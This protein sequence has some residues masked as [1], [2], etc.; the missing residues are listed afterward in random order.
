[1]ATGVSPA[2]SQ[3]TAPTRSVPRYRLTVPLSLTVLRS[4]IPNHIPGRALEI[5]EGGMGVVPASQ[6]LVG[7]T[8]RVEFL[9]PHLNSPVRA[10]A[11][12]RYQSERCFGVQFVRLPV[13]QQS[14]VRFWT[15]RQGELLLAAPADDAL[16]AAEE[17]AAEESPLLPDLEDS[18]R[19]SQIRRIVALAVSITVISAGLGWRHWQQGWAELEAQLPAKNAATVQPQWSVPSDAMAQRLVYRVI[20]E[21]PELARQAGVQGTVVL[22]TVVSA[23]GAVTQMKLVSGPNALS[24]AAMDAV[25]WWRYEPYSVNGQPAA[26][27]TTVAVDFRLTN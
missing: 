9:V 24:Q 7:E 12:V 27:E 20:P 14:I 16:G 5:G 18:S 3:G 19:K 1:M 22:D 2:F 4:G 17:D 26:V 23:E 25:R 15:R 11:V 8:V 10:T 13:E 6:L 21:Y